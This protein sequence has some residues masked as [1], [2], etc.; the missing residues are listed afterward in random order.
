MAAHVFCSIPL[1]VSSARM[2]SE[3]SGIYLQPPDCHGLGSEGDSGYDSLRRR[4]SVLDR[5]TQTHPV[6]L[7]LA[8]SGEEA[9]HILLQ[10]P[11][12][13]SGR[14]LCPGAV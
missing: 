11:P 6:W 12:G 3:V 7:L 13:V 2:E 9:S 10:Q 14:R 8:V 5:L 1:C 4:M